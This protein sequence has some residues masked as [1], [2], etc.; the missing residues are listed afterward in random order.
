MFRLLF[1][2]IV[3]ICIAML[4]GCAVPRG[5]EV[6]LAD[7]A[8]GYN[9]YCGGSGLNYSNCLEKAGDICGTRG[10]HLVNQQGEIV[11]FS[12]AVREFAPNSQS[13]T[14]GYVTQSG[15]TVTRNLLVK[16]K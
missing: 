9:I 6:F 3:I 12:I 8:R 1:I 11:P 5:K 7:G 15:S 2:L 14:I 16:C 13:T 10:Y 4:Q